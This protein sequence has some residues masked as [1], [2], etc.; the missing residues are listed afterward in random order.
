MLDDGELMTKI[1]NDMS[2]NLSKNKAHQ[3]L[4]HARKSG[5][6]PKKKG[7]LARVFSKSDKKVSGKNEL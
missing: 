5:S 2:Y 1:D 4:I 7:L 3:S 6:K